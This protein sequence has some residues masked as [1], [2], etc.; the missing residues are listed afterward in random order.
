MLTGTTY[1]STVAIPEAVIATRKGVIADR[2]GTLLAAEVTQLRP[3]KLIAATVPRPFCLSGNVTF[4][5]N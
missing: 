1:S 3:A 2:N 4:N 5:R